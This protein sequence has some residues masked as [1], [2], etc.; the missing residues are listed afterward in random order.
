MYAKSAEKLDKWNHIP[1]VHILLA[2]IYQW[3]RQPAEEASELH[4]Y[5]KDAPHNSDWQ[6]AKSRLAEIE[7]HK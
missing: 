4:K 3:E 7:P 1:E 2:Q 6:T 5:V